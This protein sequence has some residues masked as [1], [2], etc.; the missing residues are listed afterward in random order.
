MLACSSIGAGLHPATVLSL[1]RVLALG[2]PIATTVDEPLIHAHDIAIGDSVTSI[3]TQAQTGPISHVI[4][5]RFPDDVLAA[6]RRAGYAVRRRSADDDDDRT[7]PRGFWAAIGTD[8]STG[9]RSGGRTPYGQ[10]PVR[11]AS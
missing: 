1:H 8:P 6:A 4:D 9:Q 2:H 11:C 3:L 10:G 7:L 5:E